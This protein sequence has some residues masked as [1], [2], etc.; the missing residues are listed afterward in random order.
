MM[1]HELRTPLNVVIGFAEILRKHGDH[2]STEKIVDYAGDVH[3]AA[4]HLLNL[5]NDVLDL[6]KAEAGKMELQR[7]AVDVGDVI[8]RSLRMIQERAM[9]R[10]VTLIDQIEDGLPIIW[11]DERKLMQI[12]LNLLSNAVK[13]TRDGGHVT[14][15]A[16]RT[17]DESL[18]I[19]VT[20]TGIGI[21]PEHIDIALTAFG[22]IDSNLT[23]QQ[24]GTGLGLPLAKRLTELHGATFDLRSQV[25]IGTTV[26]LRFPVV[27]A[28]ATVQV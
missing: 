23:R 17:G 19:E 4:T 11:A 15:A 8:R 16:R 28:W 24:P 14:A 6:S 12:L 25:G 21:A 22:Q 13:F 9:R 1:S 7:S 27:R 18:I 5:I 26:S 10:N 20:D 2:I 3:E